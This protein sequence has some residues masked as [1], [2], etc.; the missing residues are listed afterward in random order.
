MVTRQELE[1]KR[2]I[3]TQLEDQLDL[4]GKDGDVQ[5]KAKLEDDID[6][7]LTQIERLEEE[8]SKLE[9]QIDAYEM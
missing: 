5:E 8:E 6:D 9:G 1:E 2:I 4:L 7:L 3:L